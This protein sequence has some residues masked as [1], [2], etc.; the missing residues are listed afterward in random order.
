MEKDSY[1]DNNKKE[2]KIDSTP[3]VCYFSFFTF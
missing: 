3:E 2:K 1:A